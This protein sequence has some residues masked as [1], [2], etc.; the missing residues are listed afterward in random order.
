VLPAYIG[1]RIAAALSKIDFGG[2]RKRL[3]GARR[4]RRDGMKVAQDAK[5]WVGLVGEESSPGR[6]D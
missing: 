3:P 1:V 6:D 5:S 4:S 2:R